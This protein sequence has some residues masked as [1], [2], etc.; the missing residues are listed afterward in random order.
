MC[1]HT[2]GRNH[3]GE[4]EG[5]AALTKSAPSYAHDSWP[6]ALINETPCSVGSSSMIFLDRRYKAPSSPARIHSRS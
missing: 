3:G 6:R 1:D 4:R 2:D 5:P